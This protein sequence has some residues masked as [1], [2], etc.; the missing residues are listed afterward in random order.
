MS[1]SK[2]RIGIVGWSTG[3]NSFGATKAYLHWIS[4]FGT[5]VIL[6]PH[7]EADTTL[8]LVVMPGGADTAAW[9]NKVRPSYYNSSSDQFK[10]YFMQETLKS[11]IDAGIPIWGTCLGFQ[12]LAIHFGSTITQE[13]GDH[14]TTDSEKRWLPAHKLIFAPEYYPLRDKALEMTSKSK[15][16]KVKDLEVNS[17]H[18]QGIMVDDISSDLDVIA[19]AED[20]VVELFCHPTI[21]IA[22]AQCHVEDDFNPASMMLF[23]N[24]LDK[25]PNF[26]KKKKNEEATS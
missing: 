25:S 20:G 9:F 11:Y 14:P 10:E 3:E 13:L 23:K 7:E 2:T 4:L 16:K 26:K 8:D 18:H 22:G 19:T 21:P 24:L 6:T 17:L 15:G 5:P 12:Q 1:K